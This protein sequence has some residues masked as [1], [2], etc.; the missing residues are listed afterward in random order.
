MVVGAMRYSQ[1]FAYYLSMFSSIVYNTM[2]SVVL[3]TRVHEN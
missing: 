3:Y 2:K 1:L